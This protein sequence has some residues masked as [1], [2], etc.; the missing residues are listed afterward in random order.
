MP[1]LRN[2]PGYTIAEML[3]ALVMFAIV[4]ATLTAVLTNQSRAY[5]RTQ[6]AGRVQRDL[7]TGLSL[8]PTDLRAASRTGGD[9][10]ALLDTAVELRTTVGTSIICA[11]PAAM[12]ID[13]PP[14]QLARNALTSWYAQPQAGD[15]VLLYNDV[16]SPGPEDDTWTPARVVS[17][18]QAPATA[19]VGAPFTDPVLDPPAAKPRWRLTLDIPVPA[20]VRVGAPMRF[21]RSVRYS[22]YRA[23]PGTDGWYLGYRE[24]VANAWS[25]PEPI[26]GPFAEYRAGAA[27]VAFAYYDSLGVRLPTPAV[28][29]RVARVDLTLRARTLVRNEGRADS[30]VVRDSV[31]VRVALRNRW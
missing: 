10:T 5:H 30:V 9:L 18:E 20:G 6:A 15:T 19:C 1:R 31:A 14:Q 4:A 29:T 23:A 25:A 28:P 24:L 27:G 3:I 17:L 22:L 7:R 21:L 8:L 26:A 11:L 13:L 12:T 2:R 16:V